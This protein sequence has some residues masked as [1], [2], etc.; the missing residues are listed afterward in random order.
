MLKFFETLLNMSITGAVIIVFV[1]LIRLFLKKL[2]RKY[3]YILWIIPAIRLIIP[4]SF[5]TPVSVFNYI[6][7]PEQH[8]AVVGSGEV[9]DP[10]FTDDLLPDPVTQYDEYPG[11]VPTDQITGENAPQYTGPVYT[12][13]LI[14]RE[15]ISEPVGA[16]IMT[17]APNVPH[18]P[19][20][21]SITDAPQP[22]VLTETSTAV[23]LWRAACA[24][25]ATGL[26]GMLCYL[27]YSFSATKQVV[28]CSYKIGEGIYSCP[29]A[30]TP[31]V[32]GYIKPKIYVPF[33]IDDKREFAYIIAHERTHIKRGDHI[34]KAI[35]SLIL[36]VHWFNPLAWLAFKLM[37]VD[38]E[39]SCDER[40]LNTYDIE[41]RKDYARTLLS[42]CIVSNKVPFHGMLS[43][44]ESSIKTR[45]KGVLGMK[46]PAAFVCVL[47]VAV[48]I[49]A[50]VC[51]L[52]N[53]EQTPPD[54]V[55]AE[56]TDPAETDVPKIPDGPSPYM[57]EPDSV[58]YSFAICADSYEYVVKTEYD[59]YGRPVKE[60][61]L[62]KFMQ[63]DLG[64]YAYEYDADGRLARWVIGGTLSGVD[65]S[66]SFRYSEGGSINSDVAYPKMPAPVHDR[67][68]PYTATV[69]Y[70]DNGVVKL[71]KI[72]DVYRKYDEHGR[73]TEEAGDSPVPSTA[74]YRFDDSY[75]RSLVNNGVFKLTYYN[76][77]ILPDVGY[78]VFDYGRE[79]ENTQARTRHYLPFYDGKVLKG[80]LTSS[81]GFDENAG[82]TEV[83]NKSDSYAYTSDGKLLPG[84]AKAEY[85]EKGQLVSVTYEKGSVTVN[86]VELPGEAAYVK[87]TYDDAGT[88]V[89][90]TREMTD[91][92]GQ[93]NIVYKK[94]HEYTYAEQMRVLTEKGYVYND[95]ITVKEHG[96]EITRELHDNGVVKKEI[97]ASYSVGSSRSEE[98]IVSEYTDWGFIENRTI[99]RR[100]EGKTMRYEYVYLYG[101]SGMNV[102][103]CVEKCYENG[104]LYYVHTTSYYTGGGVCSD[105]YEYYLE[106]GTV[107]SNTYR[108]YGS[109]GRLLKERYYKGNTPYVLKYS[110][111]YGDS[112]SAIVHTLEQAIDNYLL[113]SSKYTSLTG[114]GGL[115]PRQYSDLKYDTEHDYAGWVAW[116]YLQSPLAENYGLGELKSTDRVYDVAL[117]YTVYKEDKFSTIAIVVQRGSD[118][119]DVIDEIERNPKTVKGTVS[120]VGEL[121][122]DGKWQYYILNSDAMYRFY[123]PVDLGLKTGDKVSVTFNG[124]P[125]SNTDADNVTL[126]V[127]IDEANDG[128]EYEG[129]RLI[130]ET[131]TEVVD[132]NVHKTVRVYQYTYE[133]PTGYLTYFYVNDVLQYLHT[134]RYSSD[135]VLMIDSMQYYN[136]DGSEGEYTFKR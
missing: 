98:D 112:V 41:A 73:R 35:A 28:E 87:Y 118:S 92:D 30:E 126:N 6:R 44:G 3:S 132:G 58:G 121:S 62:P 99:D 77:S 55:G 105:S 51:L 60:T 22:P 10:V 108:H 125:S 110:Y 11:S 76:E 78:F 114:K 123:A 53:A 48:I 7:I 71:L 93:G 19:S 46:K 27:I 39:L 42:M 129:G 24:I 124:A 38:M 52:T 32:F 64:Y 59:S 88:L 115:N 82:T 20:E 113:L 14:T 23:T 29:N 111:I 117:D 36:C 15:P 136:A 94:T 68:K 66:V 8:A 13:E 34:I 90:E 91:I 26:I 116:R 89:H 134:L 128:K 102:L 103:D 119:F 81:V 83:L 75:E 131:A 104:K 54:P 1:V 47:A 17:D 130:K 33:G 70:H 31:F 49:T 65:V 86:G 67:N 61:Y 2:P 4:F 40:A 12:D 37:T 74:Y 69:E 9:I 101:A 95:L 109:Q 127:V 85:N 97:E 57:A 43:F 96:Y 63:A 16:P 56:T 106:D 18:S 80:V 133:I 135:N 25:W 122:A 50:A 45:I 100:S 120:S 72:G 84:L 5:E 79:G 21:P 107:G